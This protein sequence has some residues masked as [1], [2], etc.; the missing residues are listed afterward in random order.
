MDK[1]G[2]VDHLAA[3]SAHFRKGVVPQ[4]NAY[5]LLIQA[6]GPRPAEKVL[7][8]D[9]FFR[10]QGIALPPDEGE[11][12]VPF[13]RFVHQRIRPKSEEEWQEKFDQ[14]RQAA[15]HP[16]MEDDFSLVAGWLRVNQKPLELTTEATQRPQWNRPLLLPRSKSRRAILTAL[17]VS[18]LQLMRE[19]NQALRARSLLRC[20]RRQTKLSWRDLL[21]AGC[22]SRLVQRE[23]TTLGSLI[24]LAMENAVCPTVPVHPEA[25]HPTR[26]LCVAAARLATTP[27]PYFSGRQTRC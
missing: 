16:W 25:S 27:A 4:N 11:Y 17:D 8:P 20:A 7:L 1:G 14:L 10:S 13:S 26:K 23:P 9:D 21:S 12:F 15:Q 24:G 18:D 19:V 5:A 3:W 6:I 2:Y 22:L